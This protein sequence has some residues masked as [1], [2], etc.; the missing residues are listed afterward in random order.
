MIGI[1]VCIV[2]V[3]CTVIFNK[4]S[5]TD[6]EV[7]IFKY[8]TPRRTSSRAPRAVMEKCDANFDNFISHDEFLDCYGKGNFNFNMSQV[9]L[10]HDLNNDR[11][12]SIKE[13]DED[14]N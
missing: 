2:Q 14:A 6:A 8:G 11:L 1:G 4:R 9:F 12:I 5:V 10:D 3:S 13:I 7:D